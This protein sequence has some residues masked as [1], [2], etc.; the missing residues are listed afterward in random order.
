MVETKGVRHATLVALASAAIVAF[1]LLFL[2]VPVFGADFAP[3]TRLGLI[4]LPGAACIGIT[5]TL[6][7]S[8]VGRGKPAYSLYS[9]LIVTP[10]TIGLYLW[11]IPSLEAE[12]AAL[13]STIS[14]SLSFVV[15]SG[16]YYRA[17][18]RRVYRLLV[19][20]RSELN[21]LRALPRAVVAY[22]QALRGRDSQTELA[23][24]GDGILDDSQK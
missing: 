24:R 1:A 2:V 5:G 12:G 13:A 9:A 11:L 3:A 20:T 22:V 16:F 19:P 6:L 7:S 14:Y 18:G 10:V 23:T 21:D 15:A 8:I 17:T 4:L